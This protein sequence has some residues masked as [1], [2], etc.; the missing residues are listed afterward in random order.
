MTT[1]TNHDPLGE[2]FRKKLEHH[3][4]PVDPRVWEGIVHTLTK[5]RNTI[6]LW[7]SGAT[8]AAAALIAVLLMIFRPTPQVTDWDNAS[9][10]HTTTKQPASAQTTTA[11]TTTAQTTTAQSENPAEAKKHTTAQITMEQTASAQIA[12]TQTTTKQTATAQT[13]TAQTASAQTTTAQ[14]ATAQT[15]ATQIAATQTTTKQTAT[16]QTASTQ[17]TTS[18]TA[19]AQTST[20]QTAAAQTI[21]AQTETVQT[22]TAQIASAQIAATQTATT[23]PATSQP[24]TAQP[25]TPI[26]DVWLAEQMPQERKSSKRGDKYLLSASFGA[27]KGHSESPASMH[28]DVS[29]APVVA[30]SQKSEGNRYANVMSS[31]IMSFDYMYKSDFTDIRHLPPLSLGIMLRQ[32]V[33]KNLD[34]ETGVLYTYL[35]SRYKWQDFD[36]RQ[37]LHYVGIPLHL[38]L[39]LWKVHPH[40]QIY[41][42]GGLMVE[43]GVRGIYHQER[44]M[45]SQI[46]YTTVKKSPIDGLQWSLNGS[47]GFN[48]TLS[49]RF[50]FYFEPRFG[51]SFS[52]DQP[53]SMRTEWPLSIGIGAGLNFKL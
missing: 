31:N 6:W 53:M 10:A 13:I 34:F 41:L 5:Q 22:T 51:Y 4:A 42:S 43:K 35:E 9:T 48:Y 18:Q 37:G 8:V 7:R 15:A 49:K 23:Q 1:T 32:N 40:W 19:T 29:S 28:Y 20:A 50:G 52:T 25:A 30:Q 16:A 21:I 36:V 17:T 12:A 11:Q 46:L 38:V 3:Q 44:Q 2:L 14:T 27:G 26:W 39:Y 33:G 47:S 24:T 45:N